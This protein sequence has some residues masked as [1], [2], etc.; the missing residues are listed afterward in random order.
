MCFIVSAAFLQANT[1]AGCCIS[2]DI[3]HRR[4][5]CDNIEDP[6]VCRSLCLCDKEC[7]GYVMLQYNPNYCQL[8]T[9]SSC[10]NDC[11]GP[12]NTGSV[13]ELDPNAEC[14]TI[15]KWSG[16]CFI[17]SLGKFCY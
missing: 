15:G 4:C 16:G 14:G 10:P 17:K 9:N 1:N 6:T 12:A 11:R 13:E 3:F 7:K 2:N 8:A 5:F